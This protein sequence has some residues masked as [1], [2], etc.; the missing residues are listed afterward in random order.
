MTGI[1]VD[2]VI[3]TDLVNALD[4][5][6]AWQRTVLYLDIDNEFETRN[7]ILQREVGIQ[8]QVEINRYIQRLKA[9][10]KEL[11]ETGEYKEKHKGNNKPTLKGF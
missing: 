4:Q 2:D 11:V 1:G 10:V 6:E 5:L 3:L 8:T 7:E 9:K